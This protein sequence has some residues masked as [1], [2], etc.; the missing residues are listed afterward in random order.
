MTNEQKVKDFLRENLAPDSAADAI[1]LRLDVFGGM[2]ALEYVKHLV[3][4]GNA[5]DENEAWL[6]VLGTFHRMFQ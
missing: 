4:I 5:K 6:K 1:G 3:S 2:S